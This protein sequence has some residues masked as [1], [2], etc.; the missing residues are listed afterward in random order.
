SWMLTPAM[1]AS[2]VSAFW[3][4]IISYARA[5]PRMPLAEAMTTGGDA[6]APLNDASRFASR[7][8]ARASRSRVSPAAAAAPTPMKCRREIVTACLRL[9]AL[10]YEFDWRSTA[11]TALVAD[12]RSACSCELTTGGQTAHVQATGAVVKPPGEI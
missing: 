6:N 9:S 10:N 7:D 12:G 1:I 2:R 5:T 4:V 3:R 8:S 11:T